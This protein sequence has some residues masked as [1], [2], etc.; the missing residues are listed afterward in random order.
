MHGAPF[1]LRCTIRRAE[2]VG[3]EYGELKSIVYPEI[4]EAGLVE[5]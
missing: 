1:L 5:Y 2:A 4:I 3:P